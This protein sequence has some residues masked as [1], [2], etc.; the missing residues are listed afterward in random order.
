MAEKKKN[1]KKVERRP[2]VC[3]PWEEKI[4]EMAP[5]RTKEEMV[6][7]AWEDVDGLAYTYIWQLLLSA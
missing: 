5:I 4:K 3:V 2:G 7:K 1:K 6:K